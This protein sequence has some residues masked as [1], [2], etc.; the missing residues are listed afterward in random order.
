VFHVSQLK[1]FT[2]NYTLV[3]QTLSWLL[4]LDKDMVES[5]AILQHQLVKKG[6]NAIVQVLVKWTK[7]PQDATSW[8]NEN[9]M[10]TIFPKALAWGQTSSSGAGTI[11]TVEA[12]TTMAP[13]S[14]EDVN[15]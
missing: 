5:K 7:L 12:A 8:E 14:V 3:F 15:M 1:P 11:T 6:N 4:D 9:I 13:T 10:H 2:P